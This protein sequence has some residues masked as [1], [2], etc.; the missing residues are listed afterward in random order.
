MKIYT[1]HAKPDNKGSYEKPIL[2]RE[3]FNIYAFLFTF[4]WALYHRLWLVAAVIFCVNTAFVFLNEMHYLSPAHTSII[5][6]AVNILIGFHANDWLRSALTRRGYIM[7]DI[8]ASDSQLR[9]EQRYFERYIASTA[10]G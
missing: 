7:A 4:L 9:A 2:L 8:A 5:Q 1:V 6:L 10:R 3:G